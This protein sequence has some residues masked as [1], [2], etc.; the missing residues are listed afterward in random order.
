MAEQQAVEVPFNR[1]D[2]DPSAFVNL[3]TLDSLRAMASH[4]DPTSAMSN[5]RFA[6]SNPTSALTRSCS[7]SVRQIQP[8]TD[9]KRWTSP[10]RWTA[11]WPR[12]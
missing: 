6:T 1:P 3:N 5:A 11:C 7:G 4:S 8:I 10:R 12:T 2:D 9:R